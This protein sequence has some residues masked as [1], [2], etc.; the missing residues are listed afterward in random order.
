MQPEELLGF[1]TFHTWGGYG[2][3]VRERINCSIIF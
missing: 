1:S 2:L 3:T